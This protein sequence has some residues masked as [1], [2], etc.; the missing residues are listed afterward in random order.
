MNN[1]EQYRVKTKKFSLSDIRPDDKSERSGDKT[2]DALA[3]E[4]LASEINA[5]Q[6]ILYAQSKHKIL[7]ILQ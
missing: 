3:L 5:L 6:D 2:K 1:L 7:L 4:K